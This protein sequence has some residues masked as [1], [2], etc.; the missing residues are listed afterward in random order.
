MLRRI[1]MKFKLYRVYYP[2]GSHDGSHVIQNAIKGDEIS[3]NTF[4]ELAG[5][6]TGWK[7]GNPL[8]FENDPKYLKNKK[9][10][11][12]KKVVRLVV[13]P[14]LSEKKSKVMKKYNPAI[15]ICE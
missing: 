9:I 12:S 2:V 3:V 7:K 11:E 10:A 1:K 8:P 6:K 4:C 14:D 13:Y 15:V 5:F